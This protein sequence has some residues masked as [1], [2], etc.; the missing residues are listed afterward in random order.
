MNTTEQQVV[1]DTSVVS[2]L[3]RQ[4]EA[5]FPYYHAK[6]EG[7]QAFISFQTVQETWFGAYNADWGVKRR[8]DL[9][10]HL[11]R[12]E[13][14]WPNEELVDL[15]ASLRSKTRKIG[16]ELKV[17]DAWIAATALLLDCPLISHD[18]DFNAVLSVSEMTHITYLG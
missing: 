18:R 11:E 12:F 10:R 13:V 6:V 14:V 16:S 2:I 3:L 17:A 7:R 1:V 8:N 9:E 5:T 15:S 4:D